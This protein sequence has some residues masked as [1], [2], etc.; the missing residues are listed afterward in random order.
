MPRA[1]LGEAI[2]TFR[3][4]RRQIHN[5]QPWTLD[6]LAVAARDD[7]GHLSRIERGQTVPS[8]DTVLRIARALDLSWPDTE[9]LLRLSGHA[10]SYAAPEVADAREAIRWVDTAVRGYPHPVILYSVDLR[11]WYGNAL[12]LRVVGLT[13]KQFRCCIQGRRLVETMFGPCAVQ[14]H[15]RERFHDYEVSRRRTV[16]RFRAFALAGDLPED[17]VL[18]AIEHPHFR[19][20]WD[21]SS[22]ALPELSFPGEFSLLEVN[23]PGR[24]LLRFG[25]WWCPLQRDRRFV[26]VHQIPQDRHTRE[27]LAAIRSDPR[28]RPGLVCACHG[29]AGG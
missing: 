22:S 24:G 12:W 1:E 13:P 16:A 3:L 26:V 10:Q 27:A 5:G 20:L 17:Q 19:E 15:L 25:C 11:S 2:R 29:L 6:D 21:E 18:A 4:R 8:H 14:E 9:F 7:K 28:P 23:Y